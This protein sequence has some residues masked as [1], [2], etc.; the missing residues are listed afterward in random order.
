M[1]V[2]LLRKELSIQVIKGSIFSDIDFFMRLI[3]EFP[4]NVIILER[5]IEESRCDLDIL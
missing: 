1:K 2:F 5:R 4:H 3:Y